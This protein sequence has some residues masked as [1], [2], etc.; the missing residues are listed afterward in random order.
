MG[1]YKKVRDLWRSLSMLKELEKE[2]ERER[3][4]LVNSIGRDFIMRLNS[5]KELYGKTQCMSWKDPLFD[6]HVDREGV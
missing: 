2:K 3:N 5:Q 1:L 6:I 4:N